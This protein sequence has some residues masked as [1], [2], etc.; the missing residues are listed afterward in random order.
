MG[1]RYEYVACLFDC[2]FCHNPFQPLLRIFRHKKIKP[3]NSEI[4]EPL[5]I[6]FCRH[7]G[8]LS[9]VAV[10]MSFDSYVIEEIADRFAIA[11]MS[12]MGGGGNQ[13]TSGLPRRMT[14]RTGG[15]QIQSVSFGGADGIASGDGVP[16]TPK[17]L[18][19]T[20]F[21]DN[22]DFDGSIVTSVKN[23]FE[24]LTCK[25][26]KGNGID[27]VY[28]EYEPEMLEPEGKEK[29]LKLA[30][31]YTVGVWMLKPRDPDALSVAKR[32]LDECGVSYVNTDF[33]RDF[34]SS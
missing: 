17:L 22:D 9:R 20:A 24:G 18:V 32:L 16:S 33:H 14:R 3:G 31:S 7:P 30:E 26:P 19:V 13:D 25:L 4:I 23:G 21:V 27:G 5:M 34:F 8:L 6:H 10:I 1:P 15:G 28:V 2:L 29:M 12:R 11:N